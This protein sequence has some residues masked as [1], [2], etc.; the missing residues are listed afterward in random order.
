MSKAIIVDVYSRS[1]MFRGEN[2][3]LNCM[4]CHR[5]VYGRSN[6]FCVYMCI[7][8]NPETKCNQVVIIEEMHVHI[9]ISL[10][11]FTIN[12]ARVYLNCNFKYL[13]IEQP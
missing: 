6:M 3:Y 8:H 11:I 5:K 12:T 2:I 13:Y 9:A 4:T 1:R 10:I 7:K